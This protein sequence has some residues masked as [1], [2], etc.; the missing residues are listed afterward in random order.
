MGWISKISSASGAALTHLEQEQPTVVILNVARIKTRSSWAGWRITPHIYQNSGGPSVHERTVSEVR[1]RGSLNRLT[2]GALLFRAPTL[3]ACLPSG[4]VTS[5]SPVESLQLHALGKRASAPSDH[6]GTGLNIARSR[7]Q[8]YNATAQPSIPGAP[9]PSSSLNFFL[10]SWAALGKARERQND[11][12]TRIN[13]NAHQ[14]SG[15]LACSPGQQ[16]RFFCG[17]IN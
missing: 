4:S 8:I 15:T 11:R 12:K 5:V 9:R 14:S 17:H 6:F 16:V 2:T 1:V 7:D 3:R 10:I 13:P